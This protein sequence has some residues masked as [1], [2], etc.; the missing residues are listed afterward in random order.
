MYEIREVVIGSGKNERKRL[1]IEFLHPSEAILGEFLMT[2]ASLLNKEILQEI[3][4]VLEGKEDFIIGSGNRC[5]WKI[6]REK[7]IINDLFEG[8]DPDIPFLPTC[9]VETV[10][11]YEL[12]HMWLEKRHAFYKE[13]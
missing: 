1:I 9:T 11:L 12:L 7:A 10:K 8:M 2:D 3:E 6:D 13:E 5:G 4:E